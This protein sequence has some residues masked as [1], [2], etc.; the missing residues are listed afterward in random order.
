MAHKAIVASITSVQEIPGAEKIQVATVLGEQVIVSKDWGVGTRGVFFPVDV[1]LSH[2]YCANNNLYRNKDLNKD[3]SKSGFFETNRRVR[4]QPFMKV[5]SSGYFTSF[6][7]FGYIGESYVNVLEALPN[8]VEFDSVGEEKICEK[9]VSQATRDAI[10]KQNRPKQ[11]KKDYA[12]LFEKHVDSQQF[13]HYVSSIPL[14]A[15]LSFHAKVHGTSHRSGYTKVANDL[16][17]FKLKVNRLF[18]REVFPTHRWDYV[19]GTRNVI[20]RTSDKEG[21]H[22]SEAF[23]FEVAE[24]LKPHL[25]K[26]MCVYGE[27]AGYANGKPIMAVHSAEATKDKHF[28]KKFGKEI[29]YKYN[30]K[31]HEYRFH[32]YRITRLTEDGR[33][34][35]M[36]QME[37]DQW[38]L[39][40]GFLGPL[41]VA[42]KEVYN[43]DADKL[44]AKV[45]QLTENGVGESADW[46]DPTHPTEGIIIRI[47][48]GKATPMFLK[49]KNHNFRVMEGMCEALDT[50]DAA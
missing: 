48:C 23:R 39:D 26:G 47:D 27:I 43:G 11:A 14:G 3:I 30:C 19:V 4:A 35:D 32:I 36:S 6:S 42:P 21:F 41:E 10:N 15:L 25:E 49:S 17:W 28:I 12:P 33:N 20:L 38:C 40:R 22:G 8:G 18:K 45:S 34:I 31:E 37:L 44:I 29:V 9:Y 2:N 16:N 7:S 13:K 46:I 50:E 1:Q 24:Q 5:R